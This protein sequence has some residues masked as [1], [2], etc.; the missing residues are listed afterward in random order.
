MHMAI[1]GAFVDVTACNKQTGDRAPKL[2]PE[3]QLWPQE[4]A[5]TVDALT[6][7]A[8]PLS[9]PRV[10]NGSSAI[11][12]YDYHDHCMMSVGNVRGVAKDRISKGCVCVAWLCKHTIPSSRNVNGTRHRFCHLCSVPKEG[13]YSLTFTRV[14]GSLAVCK[15]RVGAWKGLQHIT[16]GWGCVAKDVFQKGPLAQNTSEQHT[17]ATDT[18]HRFCH[19]CF[20]PHVPTDLYACRRVS[21]GAQGARAEG[22]CVVLTI[23]PKFYPNISNPLSLLTCPTPKLGNHSWFLPPGKM[24]VQ[25]LEESRRLGVC[26]R[27]A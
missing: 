1:P 3:L 16:C 20:V 18:R 14:A 6:F 10:E 26:W 27:T 4:G 12:V 17:G 2:K 25:V 23:N 5:A 8:L 9:S 21:H 13:M 19:L 22:L 15:V 11:A 7:A 24:R